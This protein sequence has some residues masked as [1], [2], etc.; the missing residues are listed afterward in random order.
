MPSSIEDVVKHDYLRRSM[1][2]RVEK[3]Q[4]HASMV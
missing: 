1:L 4:V 3:K 2:D